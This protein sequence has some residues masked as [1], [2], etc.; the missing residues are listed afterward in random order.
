MPGVHGVCEGC[1]SA[2]DIETDRES[3]VS[4]KIKAGA[5]NFRFIC[6]SS[7]LSSWEHGREHFKG[8]VYG[9]IGRFELFVG[10][11]PGIGLELCQ[12]FAK[13]C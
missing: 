5:L 2:A 10:T 3:N 1:A 9:A 11:L 7:F 12:S 8:I 13:L 4:A 6:T